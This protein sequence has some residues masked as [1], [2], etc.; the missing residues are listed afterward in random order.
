MH[1]KMLFDDF[2]NL[3]MKGSLVEAL[4]DAGMPRFAFNPATGKW[5][6][7]YEG[8][9]ATHKKLAQA[10]A[11]N[12]LQ[13]EYYTKTCCIT[14]R[15]ATCEGKCGALARDFNVKNATN[16]DSES[17]AYWQQQMRYAIKPEFGDMTTKAQPKDGV[18]NSDRKWS[19]VLD[20]TE[21]GIVNYAVEHNQG[22]AITSTCNMFFKKSKG[23]TLFGIYSTDDSTLLYASRE[24]TAERERLFLEQFL[25][26][27]ENGNV[28]DTSTEGLHTWAKAVRLQQDAGTGDD[29][30]DV[31]PGRSAG[32]AALY[33]RPSRLYSSAALRNVLENIFQKETAGRTGDGI[34]R[35]S[36][37]GNA[38]VFYSKMGKVVES[39][40]QEKFGASSVISMLRGRGVKAEEIRWSGIQAF[41]DGKKSVTKDELLQFINGSMLHIDEQDYSNTIMYTEEEK[42]QRD[43][44]LLSAMVRRRRK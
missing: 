10:I 2:Y 12:N 14:G 25:E 19:P 23:R 37:R 3:S 31:A 4:G 6:T 5:V 18:K 29:S 22:T 39:M 42:I 43:K 13:M 38:P 36:E 30:G 32:D 17:I 26:E 21:W 7:E 15:C 44:L 33:G 34:V 11:E 8:K 1:P 41:L 20:S 35:K 24:S 40:K 27:Y 16:R 28:T 9:T